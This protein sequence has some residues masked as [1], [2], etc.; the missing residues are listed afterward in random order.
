MSNS[1]YCHTRE[2]WSQFTWANG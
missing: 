2:N 1:V